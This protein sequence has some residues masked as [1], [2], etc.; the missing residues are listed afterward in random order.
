MKF[1]RTTNAD[2]EQT[3]VR[4]SRRPFRR[5]T[6]ALA[7]SVAL[8]AMFVLS[9]PWRA[10]ADDEGRERECSTRTL[11]GD[12][13]L[14]GAGT[15]A[16]GSGATEAFAIV[17]MVTYDGNG[18]FTSVGTSHGQ[19]SGVRRGAP[20]S[21]TYHVNADCTGGQVT[22]IPGLPPLEDAFVIVDRGNEVRTVVISPATTMAS[23]NLRKR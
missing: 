21:G 10:T 1:D 19:T 9:A 18:T 20:A 7:A 6:V 23:A 2:P 15:R 17:A 8:A 22:N 14:V 11:R 4:T 5:R 16:L 13:G 3:D 12:Y